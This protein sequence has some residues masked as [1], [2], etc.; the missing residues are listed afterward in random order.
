MAM[1]LGANQPRAYTT[2]IACYITTMHSRFPK[3]SRAKHG[4]LHTYIPTYIHTYRRSPT[5]IWRVGHIYLTSLASQLRTDLSEGD[6]Y[7]FEDRHNISPHSQDTY[8]IMKRV[9]SP[10]YHYQV[11]Q[12]NFNTQ[13]QTQTHRAKE[14]KKKRSR[15]F[16][17]PK[18]AV[19]LGVI[20]P[21]F[22]SCSTIRAT[23]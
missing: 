22:F 12:E 17:D 10:I 7:L 18:P 15:R 11:L 4:L 23:I 9:E 1:D 13:A 5:S 21:I 19:S 3:Q 2:A 14:R 6:G 8:M 16:R 20:R